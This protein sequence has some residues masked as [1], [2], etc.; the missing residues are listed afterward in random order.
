MTDTSTG[1]LVGRQGASLDGNED[2][3]FKR[4]LRGMDDMKMRK[5]F[6]S[7]FL[8]LNNGELGVVTTIEIMILL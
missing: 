7:V 6:Q 5:C 8:N 3:L 4:R 2:C 1:D